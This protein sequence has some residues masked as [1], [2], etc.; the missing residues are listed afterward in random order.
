VSASSGTSA[1]RQRPG[2]RAGASPRAGAQAA[3]LL[4]ALLLSALAPRPAQ[5]YCRTTTCDPTTEDCDVDQQG[6]ATRGQYL[7]WPDACVTYAVQRSGSPLRGI[8]AHATDQA[9]RAAF[10]AW[11]GADCDGGGSPSLG[12]IPLG[13]ASC[14]RV[15]FNPAESGRPLTPN[16][17]LVIYRDDAWPYVNERFVIARTSIT[18][19]PTTGAIFDADIEINSFRNEFSLSDAMVSNDL[20]SVLTHEVGHFLGLDHT[21]VPNATMLADYEL[22]DLGTRTL[23]SDDAAGICAIYAPIAGDVSC[24]GNTGP[25]HGYSRECGTPSYADAS[26]LSLSMPPRPAPHPWLALWPCLALGALGLARRRR[27]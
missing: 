26:C 22:S 15:E 27:H 9:L 24:P 21:L 7:Y 8:S 11:L 19:D 17:N 2:A 16:A 20:Q 3:C 14:D 5:A 10:S 13:G 6:C 12:V 4:G 25:H 1:R 18:F 23:S